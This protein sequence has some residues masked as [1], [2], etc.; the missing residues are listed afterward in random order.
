M[1][2]KWFLNVENVCGWKICCFEIEYKVSRK[3]NIFGNEVNIKEYLQLF[4]LIIF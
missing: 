3:L 2:E 4:D 1:I